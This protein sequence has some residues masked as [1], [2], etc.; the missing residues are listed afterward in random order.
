M[1]WAIAVVADN[2]TVKCCQ[3]KPRFHCFSCWL[4]VC[5]AHHCVCLLL[6]AQDFTFCC[7]NISKKL[8][9]GIWYLLLCGMLSLVLLVLLFMLLL[10]CQCRLENTYNISKFTSGCRVSYTHVHAGTHSCSHKQLFVCC[11]LFGAAT[12]GAC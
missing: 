11:I 4:C 8:C 12:A 3:L 6:R 2:Y 10:L 5:C 9:Y 7:C 1:L